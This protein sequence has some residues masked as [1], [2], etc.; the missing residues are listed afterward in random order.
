[1]TALTE[2][3]VKVRA[4]KQS[5]A[6][7]QRVYW[8]VTERDERAAPE[9][10]GCRAPD[11]DPAAGPCSGPID[12]HH[13]GIKLGGKRVTRPNRVVCLCDGHHAH[14]APTHSRLILAWLA[15]IEDA[16]E[17]QR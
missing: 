9:R 14:W 12:R 4:H 1:M 10:H 17:S 13:A 5:A 7:D 6:E 2:P 16:R 8:Y 11:I 15:D 3:T